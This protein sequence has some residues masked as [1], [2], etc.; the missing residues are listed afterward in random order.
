MTVLAARRV[1]LEP[2]PEYRAA[3]APEL[4]TEL[5]GLD[6][7][8]DIVLELEGVLALRIADMPGKRIETVKAQPELRKYR[9]HAASELRF[10]FATIEEE[11]L[12]IVLAYFPRKHDYAKRDLKTAAARLRRFLESLR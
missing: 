6:E 9:P 5:A 7:M 3:F 8:D 2:K 12:R 10:F 11:K 1:P 4:V